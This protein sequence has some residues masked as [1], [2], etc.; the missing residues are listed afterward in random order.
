M[1]A[2]IESSFGNME[3]HHMPVPYELT[4]DSSAAALCKYSN[5]GKGK[6]L[7]FKS[8]PYGIPKNAI[9]LGINKK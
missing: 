5:V 3:M 4:T 1:H 9:D 2:Q 6:F 8:P 7:A